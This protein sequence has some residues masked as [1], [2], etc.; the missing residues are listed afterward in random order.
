V[1]SA[2]LVEISFFDAKSMPAIDYRATERMGRREGLD[3]R[4]N[5]P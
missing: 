5:R 2:G 1:V 4:V 3:G